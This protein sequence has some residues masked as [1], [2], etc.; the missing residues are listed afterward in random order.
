M[1]LVLIFLASITG[2]IVSLVSLVMFGATWSQAF[3][4]YLAIATVPAAVTLTA[5]YLYMLVTRTTT[6]QTETQTAR[7]S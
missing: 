7:I 2:C 6:R 3:A 4:L 5:M 1:A